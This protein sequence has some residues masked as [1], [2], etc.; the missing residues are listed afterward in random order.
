M[1]DHL[2]GGR[3][4]GDLLSFACA[5]DE[6]LHAVGAYVAV[7]APCSRRIEIAVIAGKRV[8]KFGYA[9]AKSGL[10]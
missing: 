5:I 7:F 10:S 4:F 1:I 9:A 2:G 3:G 6:E 8:W